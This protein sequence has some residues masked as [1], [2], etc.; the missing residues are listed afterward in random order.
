M[1]RVWCCPL[2]AG[3]TNRVPAAGGLLSSIV[4]SFL[5]R[6]T[7]VES[8][9]TKTLYGERRDYHASAKFADY[10]RR[11]GDG[12]RGAF[13]SG[14]RDRVVI[15]GFFGYRVRSRGRDAQRRHAGA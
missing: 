15:S 11:R 12:R 2:D 9:P 4:S 5:R 3:G 7:R 8:I 13:L 6:R 10:A 1:G 14:L